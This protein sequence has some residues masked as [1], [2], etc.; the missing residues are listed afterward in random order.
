MF[1]S[2]YPWETIQFNKLLET[3]N[4]MVFYK[5]RHQNT[6]DFNTKHDQYAMAP[7]I[8]PYTPYNYY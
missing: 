5:F 4:A 1:L 3:Q 8:I 7:R 2:F 6:T